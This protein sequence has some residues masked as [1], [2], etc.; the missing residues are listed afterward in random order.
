MRRV[1]FWSMS[2]NAGI[3]LFQ[4]VQVIVNAARNL[5]SGRLSQILH[6]L[7]IFNYHHLKDLQFDFQQVRMSFCRNPT[8]G[9][10]NQPFIC[11]FACSEH[12]ATLPAHLFTTPTS[13]AACHLFIFPAAA[14]SSEVKPNGSLLRQ[15]CRLDGI[16]LDILSEFHFD[17]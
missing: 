17:F 7:V 13:L 10:I 2:M 3:F 12:C 5:P 16:Y 9:L 11:L 14:S 15:P 1:Q 6:P 4:C 8:V